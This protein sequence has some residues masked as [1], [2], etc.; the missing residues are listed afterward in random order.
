METL[1][2]VTAAQLL[3]VSESG[4]EKMCLQSPAKNRHTVRSEKVDG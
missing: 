3:R 2:I 1:A 4:C